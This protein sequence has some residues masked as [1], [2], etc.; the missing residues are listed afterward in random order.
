VIKPVLF[1]ASHP[2]NPDLE[3][4]V[5]MEQV[6]SSKYSYIFKQRHKQI[7]CLLGPIISI[8][9]SDKEKG[10]LPRPACKRNQ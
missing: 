9:V 1:V 7:K 10:V 3:K 2:K 6:V 5:S 4:S 8:S